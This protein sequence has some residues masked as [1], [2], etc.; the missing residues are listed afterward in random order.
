PGHHALDGL[1]WCEAAF[2]PAF[3]ERVL[4]DRGDYEV[5]QDVAG[6]AVLCFKGRRSGFMPEY[7]DHPVKDRATWE[8]NVRWRL[9]PASAERYEDLDD[10]MAW[11]VEAAGQGKMICQRVIGGYMYLRSLFGP[12]KTLYAF[13]DAPDLIHDCM[14][15]W[16]ALADAV[17]ARHQARVT[18]D[19]VFLA[20]DICYNAGP[21]ISP[22][23]IR[24]FL[25]PYYQQLLDNVR[26]RQI[27]RTRHLYLQIDT[28]GRAIDVI[29]LYREIGMDAMSPLEVA[30]GCDVVE[31]GR[32]YPD[33]AL[34]GGIDKRVLA[35]APE[36]IDAM[37][38]RILPAMRARGGYIPTCDHGVPAEV[39][40]ANYRHYRRRCLEL[41]G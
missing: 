1:G 15:A 12:E 6:R 8:E 38:E 35:Q 20:E 4:E 33:L 34:F 39:P 21:L 31:I 25:F 9:D 11:A 22:R 26:R 10:R 2:Y 17:I 36:A 40:L 29:P 41:G 32:R 19:E 27:D 13:Y 23:M 24:E 5:V 3:E 7:L 28:D 16:L 30:A 37:V 14:R 18:L